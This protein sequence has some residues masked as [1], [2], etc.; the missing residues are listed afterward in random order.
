M[1]STTKTPIVTWKPTSWFSGYRFNN[2]KKMGP[3]TKSFMKYVKS[4]ETYKQKATKRGFYRL[5]KKEQLPGNNCSFFAAIKDSGIVCINRKWN[6]SYTETW[7][8]KGPNW[9][10]YLNGNLRRIK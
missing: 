1:T 5:I 8:T 4:C 9:D 10:N 3:L 7:Y 2:P 6:G